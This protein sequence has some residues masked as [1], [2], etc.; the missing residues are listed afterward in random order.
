[1]RQY[2]DNLFI[3]VSVLLCNWHW[4]SLCVRSIV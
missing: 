4:S 2:V 3:A 1:V